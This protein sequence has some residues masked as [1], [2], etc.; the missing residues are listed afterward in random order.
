MFNFA[1]LNIAKNLVVQKQYLKLT[2]LK[3]MLVLSI[4]SALL[5]I[6]HSKLNIRNYFAPNYHSS[7]TTNR[8]SK[9]LSCWLTDFKKLGLFSEKLK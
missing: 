3:E 8:Q 2:F 7:N 4:V 5:K 9:G 6:K 1:I